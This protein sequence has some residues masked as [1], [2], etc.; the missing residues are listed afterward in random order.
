MLVLRQYHRG[1]L[2]G[3]ELEPSLRKS[4]FNIRFGQKAGLYGLG[5]TVACC[6]PIEKTWVLNRY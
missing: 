6:S 3:W 5:A 1:G 2:L 4:G